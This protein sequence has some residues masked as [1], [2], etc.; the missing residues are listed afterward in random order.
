MIWRLLCRHGEL[1][2]TLF[3]VTW[4]AFVVS[5]AMKQPKTTEREN[6]RRQLPHRVAGWLARLLERQSVQLSQASALV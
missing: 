5:R 3:N 6:T 2:T 4:N 1:L